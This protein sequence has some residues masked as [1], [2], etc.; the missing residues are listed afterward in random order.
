MSPAA[1]IVCFAP[2]PWNAIWRNRHQLL[3]RLARRHRVLYVEPRPYLKPLLAEWRAGV[4]GWADLWREPLRQVQQG[5]HVYHPPVYAP[6]SGQEPLA[7]LTAGLRRSSMRAALRQAGM[8]RPVLWL[9]R[10]DQA[11]VIG[12]LDER[13]VLYHVVDEY[14]AYAGLSPERAEAVRQREQVL[15]R[16][17]DIVIVTSQALLNNKSP[18]NPRTYCVP[19]AV[20]YDAFFRVLQEAPPSPPEF[21]PLDR[22]II[23]YVGAI[24]DKI[25]LG[26]LSTVA[27][28]YPRATVVLVGPVN[29]S[30]PEARQELAGL[31]A[32]PNVR[33]LGKV[34]VSDVP[35]YMLQCDVALLPYRLNEWT[36]HINSLKLLEYLALGLP[37]VAMALPMV[38]G[39][40]EIVYVADGA[41]GFVDA[42]AQAL[43]EEAPQRRAQRQALAAANTWDERVAQIERILEES[44]AVREDR[45]SSQRRNP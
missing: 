29:L 7:G 20:D 34:D 22:P 1:D 8:R 4:M 5:L 33:F 23:G 37:V 16:R 9:T 31:Q 12:E 21:G 28:R 3:T 18:F 2:D 24:N 15:M 42:I 13:L 14:S 45:I 43:L 32:Q 19:N 40:E 41:E 36:R 26:L 6:I 39:F 11:D 38:T 17:A 35:R 30:T 25:D 27:Q 10:P 44:L